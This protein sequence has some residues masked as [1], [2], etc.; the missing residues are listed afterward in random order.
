MSEFIPNSFQTPNMYID[1]YMSYLTDAEFRVLI[2]TV[3]RIFGFQKRQDS[4]SLSQYTNGISN[5]YGEHLDGGCGVNSRETVRKALE[6]L[7]GFNLIIR[8]ARN[9]PLLNAGDTYS[10]QLDS[11]QVDM[12][13]L[14]R[15]EENRK[16]KARER[17]LKARVKVRRTGENRDGGQSDRPPP[18]SGTNHPPVSGTNHPR[19]VG[20]TTPG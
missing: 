7:I 19:S 3:R 10:L 6:S 11:S 13:A 14:E 9:N 20:Q 5:A 8:V 4:I 15:R 16:S 17:T 1:R 18:V 12:L 2:Y